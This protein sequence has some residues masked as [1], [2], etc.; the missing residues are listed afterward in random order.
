MIIPQD[1]DLTPVPEWIVKKLSKVAEPRNRSETIK[2]EVTDRPQAIKLFK[3]Y[4][5][6][7]PPIGPDD[8]G[9]D[10]AVAAR[11]GDF[12]LSLETF[13]AL[14]V[15]AGG[16]AEYAETRYI[17]ANERNYR[18]NEIG[19]DTP[20][21]S[22]E[23]WA[24][25]AANVSPQGTE[26]RSTE[27]EGPAGLSD[28]EENE[29]T[30]RDPRDPADMP[31]LEFFD[32]D[33]CIPKSPEGAVGILYGKRGDHKTNLALSMLDLSSAVRI[34]Y[35]AG[36]GS[37]GVERDRIATRQSIKG[38]IKI[39]PRVPLFRDPETVIKFIKGNN[40]YRPDLV[41]LDTMATAL[42]GEDENSSITASYLTDNGP[43][44]MI[45]RAWNCTVILIAHSGKDATKGVRGTSGFEGNVDFILF[46][47]ANKK[48]ATVKLHVDKMRDG[49]DGFDTWWAYDSD[50]LKVPVPEKI[51][52]VEYMKRVASSIVPKDTKN[53]IGMSVLS[54]LRLNGHHDWA[55][56]IETP[57]LATGMTLAERGGKP[58]DVVEAAEWDTTRA[59]WIKSLN[60]A[61]TKEWGKKATKEKIQ[62][63]GTKMILRW[64]SKPP[65]D[66]EVEM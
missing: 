42:A 15:E 6:D 40:A 39:L 41:I 32:T 62:P 19:C 22:Q 66:Q 24:K 34:L 25:F 53:I 29:Y 59:D 52:E 44:G 37:Y 58:E 11:A 27:A 17:N 13:V 48:A 1:Y 18:Q 61:K 38:R 65:E 7:K 31:A 16:D 28:E 47:E 30:A 8:I 45:K 60:N 26:R 2:N 63:G 51:S 55:T 46:V 36:E 14:C 5:E 9:N 12:N 21:T 56:G 54:W 23:K 49:Y 64:F 4:L 20:E 3:R 50:P 43:C 35:A 10:Y 33:K 57:D